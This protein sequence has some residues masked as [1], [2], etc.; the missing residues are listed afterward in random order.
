[1]NPYGADECL[2]PVDSGSVV[3]EIKTGY[4]PKRMGEAI[5]GNSVVVSPRPDLLRK[6]PKTMPRAENSGAVEPAEDGRT[7]S[8]GDASGEELVRSLLNDRRWD[9][10]RLEA[11]IQRTGLPRAEIQTY[12]ENAEIARRPWGRPT[13]DLFAR[14][15]RRVTVRE[16]ISLLRIFVAKRTT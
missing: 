4:S 10:W 13:A 6:R 12:L 3:G 14:A 2:I 9:F 1:M 5:L 15:D 16:I 8:H 7:A 11:L